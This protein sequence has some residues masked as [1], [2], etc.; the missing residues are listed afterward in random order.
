MSCISFLFGSKALMK[1]TT[2]ADAEFFFFAIMQMCFIKSPTQFHIT[3]FYPF[4]HNLSIVSKRH[5][6]SVN[7]TQQ[8]KKIKDASLLV[9]KVEYA[10]CI[11]FIEQGTV[12]VNVFPF[13]EWMF[14]CSK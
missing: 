13:S 3:K 1:G 12:Q 10:Y 5:C 2:F 9:L 6:I 14:Y 7:G 4:F 11:H 8:N